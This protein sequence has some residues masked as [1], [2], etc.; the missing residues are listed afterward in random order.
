VESILRQSYSQWELWLPPDLYQDLED[1]RLRRLPIGPAESVPQWFDRVSGVALG[2]YVLPIPAY[3]LIPRQAF[4][5]FASAIIESDSADLIYSDEDVLDEAGL[6]MMP[7]FKPAW[8]PELALG[9]NFVGHLSA[10]RTARVREVGGA[11]TE[12][13]SSEVC[14][15][16]LVLRTAATPDA[17]ETRHIPQVLC[18]RPLQT[19]EAGAFPGTST[20]DVVARHLARLGRHGAEVIPAPSVST[21][22]RVIWPSPEPLPRVSIVVPTRDQPAMIRR[23]AE[24]VLSGTDYTN[25]EM[26][27]VDN[28]SVDHEA[29]DILHEL[30]TDA[31][32]RVLRHDAPFNFSTLNN[33]AASQ[34]SGSVLV[35]L[36]DDTE[37]R[38][39]G[40]LRELVSHVLRPEI[41][42]V[43]ARLLYPA[44]KVQHAGVV[45]AAGGPH[46]QFRLCD[47]SEIGPN[48]ELSLSRSVTAVTAACIALR[49]SVFDEVGGLD[50]AFAVAFG[51]VDLCL[52]VA[53]AGY[54]IICT[55][56][57][58]LYHHESVSR[59][60][61]DTPEKRAR[62]SAELARLR[63][64]WGPE[65]RVD[66]FASPQLVF[67]WDD[68]GTW[69]LP[70]PTWYPGPGST[71]LLPPRLTP[72][73][74]ARRAYLRIRGVT[75]PLLPN[76][77]F[78]SRFYV[79]AYPEAASYRLGA[80]QH[81]RRHG[82][83]MSL[84][85]NP[86]F[87][88]GWYLRRYPDIAASGM[89]PLDHYYRYGARDGRDPSPRFSTRWYAAANPDVR[90]G[91]HHPL[92]HFLTRG[93]RE[94]RKPRP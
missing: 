6:R 53:Q 38:G 89:N 26:L 83:A 1:E 17:H 34:A 57:A 86:Y 51:D 50:E 87:D 74:I 31:R 16:D 33:Q 7:R 93:E 27:I 76:P 20:Q 42:I 35:L 69:G 81:F 37:V 70:R 11:Q 4:L 90:A 48:G 73:A 23:C 39:R 32:V 47:A 19:L 21:W 58:E 13:P 10:F 84:N 82:V 5:E 18:S 15:Y 40:W 3:A 56:F 24:G 60:A 79:A 2:E 80:Y 88:T 12:S 66:R 62:F 36:N 91:G 29:M 72:T 54:R 64:R 75:T 94:G 71:R 49:K 92:Q 63:Q 30:G 8:D 85:P 46:H 65:M 45:M 78:S 68:E 59:G 77:L 44:D 14:L 61:E 67:A 28:G 9:R 22:N 43:G 55:P 25:L 52:R 41:G